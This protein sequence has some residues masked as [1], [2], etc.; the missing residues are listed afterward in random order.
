MLNE[1]IIK[2]PV[3]IGLGRTGLSFVRYFKYM[4]LSHITVWDQNPSESA[5]NA[6]QSIYPNVELLTDDIS[7]CDFNDYSALCLSP[8]VPRKALDALK[9]RPPIVSE[10]DIFSMVN[11]TPTIGVTGS[12]G[13]STTCHLLYAMA[14]ANGK[15]AILAGNIG[16]PVLDAYLDVVQNQKKIDVYILE[17]SSFQLESIK[18][19]QLDEAVVLNVKQDHLDRYID[20]YHYA[21]TKNLIYHRAHFGLYNLDHM[22][23]M[24]AVRTP[25]YQTFA[26]NPAFKQEADFFFDVESQTIYHQQKVLAQTVYWHKKGKHYA[27]N[28]MAAL[29]LGLHQGWDMAKMLAV[30]QTYIGLKHRCQWVATIKEVAWYNDSKA[31]NI[32]SVLSAITGVAPQGRQLIWIAGGRGKD[33]DYHAL[34]PA[35]QQH[36]KT[37]LLIGEEAEAISNALR[38]CVPVEFIEDLDQAVQRAY[39][40]AKPG[41]VVLL[42]PACTSFDMFKNFEER[43]DCFIR[44]VNALKLNA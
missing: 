15:Q 6:L 11:H 30:A 7:K 19:Q 9:K 40:I 33:T 22:Q 5:L 20:F 31:T 36:V 2:N 3:V 26:T 18:Y 39:D 25:I 16:L 17:M 13:K 21:R 27:E 44:N 24:P 29:A 14:Q 28:V 43:G 38:D 1:S 4:G 42:S 23:F 10:F 35:V 37:A 34:K 32:D 8:G 41:D 12:N